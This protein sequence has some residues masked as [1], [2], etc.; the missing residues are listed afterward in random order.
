MI[1]PERKIRTDD[2]GGENEPQ[3]VGDVH[4]ETPFDKPNSII[5]AETKQGKMGKKIKFALK[6]DIARA[7]VLWQFRKPGIEREVI[8]GLADEGKKDR[9]KEDIQDKNV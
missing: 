7:E 8:P 4:S 5:G 6:G 1:E 3:Q 2:K 9:G